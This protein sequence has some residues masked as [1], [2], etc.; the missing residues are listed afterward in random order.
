MLSVS[1]FIDA[2][3]V[4]SV[5]QLNF[6][7]SVGVCVL[8]RYGSTIGEVLKYDPY[9]GTMCGDRVHMF[10]QYTEIRLNQL[11][12][13]P[14]AD[15]IKVFIKQEPHKISKIREGRLR[16]IS[17]VSMLDSMV[18][19]LLFGRLMEKASKSLYKTP[20]TIGWSPLKGGYRM[21]YHAARNSVRRP[22]CFLF[23]D[24]SA[25]DWS[26]PL[27]LIEVVREIIETLFVSAPAWWRA[28]VK[29]RFDLLFSKARF[30]FADGTIIMQ[31][32]PGIMKSGCYLTILINSIAQLFIHS[33]ILQRMEEIWPDLPLLCIGDDTSI[34]VSEE[35]SEEQVQMYISSWRELGFHLKVSQSSNFQYAGFECSS[36]GFIPE[37]RDKHA[38]MLQHLTY[39]PSVASSTL[40]A[41]QH[42]YYFDSEVLSSLVKL[43]MLRGL[44]EAI[45]APSV[46]SRNIQ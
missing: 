23:V 24:K 25:W 3:F 37:Y 15:P 13:Q 12:T 16:L 20:I 8:D 45:V 9:T 38:F 4:Q 46:L 40:V 35:V 11:L 31:L 26:V 30:V 7:A 34:T 28:A 39:E 44:L 27:W 1:D 29:V 33:L 41:Y 6:K 10:R 36:N 42:L 18:D 43:A 21:L 17:S 14:I 19:R 5:A 2:V 22:K 32:S